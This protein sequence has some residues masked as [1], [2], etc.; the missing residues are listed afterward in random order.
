MVGER[1]LALV[2]YMVGEQLWVANAGDC[3][4]VIGRRVDEI[5]ASVVWQQIC[6]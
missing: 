3:R 5:R 2:A 4:A 6:T 1:R